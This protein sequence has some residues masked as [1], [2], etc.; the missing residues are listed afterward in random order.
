MEDA[1]SQVRN[2]ETIMNGDKVKGRKKAESE[3]CPGYI[4]KNQDIS[5]S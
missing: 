2:T 1:S 3:L 4:A 5:L